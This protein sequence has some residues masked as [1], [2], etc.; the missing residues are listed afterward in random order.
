MKGTIC[1]VR[2]LADGRRMNGQ[3]V[4]T[5]QGGTGLPLVTSRGGGGSRT[6]VLWRFDDYSP[7]AVELKITTELALDTFPG[8]LPGK[9]PAAGPGRTLRR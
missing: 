5:H 7:S 2:H 9:F 3:P 4:P 6:R 8:G 1:R